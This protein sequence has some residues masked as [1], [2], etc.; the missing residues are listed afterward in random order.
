MRTAVFGGS[1]NPIHLGHLLLADEVLETLGADRVLFVPAGEP[2]HKSAATVAP[3]ADRLAM[4]SLAIAGHPGFEVSD[5]EVRRAGASYTVDTLAVLARPG[6]ELFLVLGS[7]MFLDLLTWR[8]PRRIAGL[9]RLVVVPRSGS[10]FDPESAAAQKVLHAIGL[11]RFASVPVETAPPSSVL[12]V[13]ATSLPLSASD[14]RRR[15]RQGRSLAYRVP[16]AVAEYIR[17]HGLY[18][19]QDHGAC[20]AERGATRTATESSSD[21]RAPGRSIVARTEPRGGRTA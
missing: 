1:F 12:V 15:V 5:I 20:T 7:E 18:R 8:Q 11:E 14:L 6:D 3:A 16:E 9:A 4:V 17:A 2:P 10:A 19:D 13:H 21:N